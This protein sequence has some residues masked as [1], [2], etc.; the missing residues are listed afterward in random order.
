MEQIAQT[1]VN[2][3]L[4]SLIRNL[5]ATQSPFSVP[6]GLTLADDR[7]QVSSSLHESGVTTG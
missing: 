5:S 7:S 4:E 3:Q 1:A 6:N 2:Q